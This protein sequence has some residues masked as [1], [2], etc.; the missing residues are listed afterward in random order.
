MRGSGQFIADFF[1]DNVQDN[2]VKYDYL[3]FYMGTIWIKGRGDLTPFYEYIFQKLK[4][5]DC[6]WKYSFPRLHL[7]DPKKIFDTSNDEKLGDYKPEKALQRQF[8]LN[9]KDKQTKKYQ[10]ELDKI[11]KEEYKEAK[12]KPLI[13]IVHA[14][15]NIYGQLPYGH[16]QKEFE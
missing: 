12:Y 3:D 11:Y 1:N 5:I 10:E 7:I 2:P 13:Q 8:E 6:D 4:D 15:K 16:P 9:E 14:Y